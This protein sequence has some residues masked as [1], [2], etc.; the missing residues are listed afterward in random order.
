M[1]KTIT[2]EEKT[3]VLLTELKLEL[4]NKSLDETIN[5]LLYETNKYRGQE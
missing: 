4:R 3:W 5:Y 2:L 1:K